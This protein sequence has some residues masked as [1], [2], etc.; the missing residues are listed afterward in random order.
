MR[1][2]LPFIALDLPGVQIHAA[3][4][5]IQQ[6]A[7][8]GAGAA[9]EDGNVAPGQIPPAADLLRIAGRHV[10][11]LLPVGH[12]D[13]NRFHPRH[14]PF[15]IGDIEALFIHRVQVAGSR[16][17]L[18]LIQGKQP[19][20]AAEVAAIRHDAVLMQII[21]QNI[22]HDIL[23]G[24]DEGGLCPVGRPKQLAAD[25]HP[26]DRLDALLMPRAGDVGV[27]VVLGEADLAPNLVGVD[28]A[29]ADQLIDGG[30]AHMEEL[31][32]LLCRE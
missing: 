3:Q 20:K 24:D 32:D 15:D 31:C 9:I 8:A 12:V 14:Q 10:K 22:Q 28:L 1:F 19:F 2:H 26:P 7:R 4:L 25:L 18:F 29:P 11:A 6:D 13:Q 16:I 21:A 17:H 23:T 30:F 27:H 5:P